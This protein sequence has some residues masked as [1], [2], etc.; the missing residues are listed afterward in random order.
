[1][2]K[3]TKHTLLDPLDYLLRVIGDPKAGDARRDRLA[4]AALPYLHP[5]VHDR[6]MTRK[7]KTR[8]AVARTMNGDSNDEWSDV[9]R[10]RE[11]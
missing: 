4:L 5:K 3:S 8:Q 9:L 11:E 10:P 1:M 2:N 7:E 6:V